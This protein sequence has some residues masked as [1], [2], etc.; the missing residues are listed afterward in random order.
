MR[1]GLLASSILSTLAVVLAG[2]GDCTERGYVREASGSAVWVVADRTLPAGAHGAARARVLMR[3]YNPFQDGTCSD[4]ESFVLEVT[5][6]CHLV[7]FVLDRKW[8]T[9][10]SS[11]G[12]FLHA[13]VAL[14]AEQRREIVLEDGRRVSGALDSGL[15]TIEPRSTQLTLALRVQSSGAFPPGALFRYSADLTWR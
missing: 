15:L 1:R 3:S 10:R 9:G 11:N 7:A 4:D 2:C 6:E 8:D 14:R 13:D 12:D 5:P